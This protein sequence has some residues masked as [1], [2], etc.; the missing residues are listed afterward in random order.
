ML[1]TLIVPARY[2]AWTQGP[3]Q[4]GSSIWGRQENFLAPASQPYQFYSTQFGLCEHHSR[5]V[6]VVMRLGY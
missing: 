1:R 5:R 3:A 6:V 2:A 4:Q